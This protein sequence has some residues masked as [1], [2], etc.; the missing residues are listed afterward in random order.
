MRNENEESQW[1]PAVGV[2]SMTY[3]RPFTSEHYPLFRRMKAAGMDFCE[4]LV[5]E[6]GELDATDAGHA[7]RQAGLSLVFAARINP[8]RNL[9][10]DDHTVRRSG[11]EYLRRCV[12]IAVAA[13]AK[14]IGGPLYGSPL[15]FAGRVPEPIDESHRLAR[16]QK[17]V[18]GL[19][20]AGDYAAQHGVEF[21]IEP[22]N[23]F[24]TD[25]CNTARQAVELAIQ[26]GSPAVNVML[27]TFHMNMEE[28][29][30]GRAIRRA[31]AYLVHFQAN[32]NHRGYLGTGHLNWAEICHVLAEIDYRGP[33]TLE[34]FRRT[35]TML[36]LPLAQWRSPSYDEDLDLHHSGAFLRAA[37]HAA[38]RI[39]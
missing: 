5:P 4:L 15:V 11:V 17:V 3:T 28:D 25:F 33:I 29:D 9:A 27:D 36:S 1:M 2:N 8:H 32:E 21:A 7:A 35:E 23:R 16:V 30:L 24:E 6:E 22:L 12:D 13:G 26:V 20:E 18:A 37:L 38:R 39:L 19:K 14:I 10:S 31:A 34:P